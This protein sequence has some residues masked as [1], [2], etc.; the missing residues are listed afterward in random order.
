METIEQIAD[1]TGGLPV[2]KKVDGGLEVG[3]VFV[4][5]QIEEGL[6][7]ERVMDGRWMIRSSQGKLTYPTRV[8]EVMGGNGRFLA[9]LVKGDEVGSGSTLLAA[10]KLL[11]DRK[12][13]AA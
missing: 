7:A 3:G 12:A 13:G 1:R 8:G 4:G 9:C 11:A 2:T 5:R 6:F 10:A